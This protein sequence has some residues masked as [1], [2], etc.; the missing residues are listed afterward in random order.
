M[1]PE[2][3]YRLKMVSGPDNYD[4]NSFLEQSGFYYQTMRNMMH[5]NNQ[6]KSF[7]EIGQFAGVSN[8]DW[9]WASLFTDLDNDG[10]KDLF[11]TNGVKRD[12]TN[13]DFLNYAVQDRINQN[14]TGVETAITD[15]LENMPATIEE[16][17]TYHNNGDLTFTKV[18][19]AWG[20]NQKSLSNG[21]VYADLDNDGD[22]DL[23][24]NNIDENPF[25][26]R[27]NSNLHTANHYLKINLKGEGKNTYGVGA[28]VTLT[29]G[30]KLLMQEMMPTRGFQSSVDF[31]LIFGLGEADS[32]DKLKIIW[33]DGKVHVLTN[34]KADETI[35]LNQKDA[36]IIAEK[37]EEVVGKTYFTD[38]TM[39]S[40]IPY[41]HVEN[42]Y[43]DFKREQLL[44]H[45]LST[46]GPSIT[47]AD[48]NN[49]GL[50]DIYVGGAKGSEGK[51]FVQTPSGKF[52]SVNEKIFI[53]DKESEDIGSLLFDADKDGDMDLY[54]VSG[55]NDFNEDSKELQD[56]LYFN[57]GRGNFTKKTMALPEMITSGSCVTA[58][59]ID[60]DGDLDLFIGGR[61][62]P[63]KYPTS[64]R[65]YILENNGKGMFTDIT[66]TINPDLEYPG[67]V[68]DAI[69]TDIDN[70]KIK[71][72]IIVGEWMNIR[73]FKN[74]EGKLLESS[75][76]NGLE[77]SDGWWNSIEEGDF[78]ND[79][80]MDYVIGNF[81]RNSQ[82]K[83]SI[84]EPVTL[85][86]K[87]FDNNGSLDP[88]LTYY[89]LGEE[90]P[91]F[92]KDD[93]VGQLSGLKGKYLNYSDYAAAKITDVFSSE[94]LQGAL[95]VK[96]KNFDSSYM[97]N[98]GN[99]KFKL[100]PLPVETQFSPIYG[101][102]C[103]D[104]NNDGNEDIIL[105]GN[106]F[107]TRVKFGRYDANKGLLLF[108]DGKGN[109]R[110]SS[111]RESGF[112]ID[113]EVRDISKITL[114]NGTEVLLFVRNNDGV[115][116]FKIESTK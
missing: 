67:M 48:L 113:G 94:E 26:Y 92:S 31:N 36:T 56:R 19:E 53:G 21:A 61:L 91:V 90:F 40:L 64:P 72:L 5:L 104:V 86:T 78:D 88:I 112:N 111:V 7:S 81:G 100:V 43:N 93:M 18:N 62:V 47:K 33:P 58:A 70:D 60:G 41:R 63:G 42:D 79:G 23:V 32:I 101:I 44:P 8:T 69:W 115:A 96:A 12:Y 51:M 110:P 116:M 20:L 83:T 17:Y 46:Q 80:D 16:N 99:G 39:D 3:N 65:S 27:N 82:L 74:V 114:T 57:D 107:G 14:K 75:E 4:K 54:V 106:F 9:S 89:N 25:V 66:F 13:M 10:F 37:S 108:G 28:K 85:Y 71:D 22:L 87:D 29:V 68:T 38:I 1:L 55:G 50:E 95:V 97:E 30:N 73:T 105:G 34:V 103:E 45:K 77:D 109:F 102:L 15:L 84:T 76:T 35:T 11:I 24:I 49:D 59:D 6:G 2:N 98:L 52:L